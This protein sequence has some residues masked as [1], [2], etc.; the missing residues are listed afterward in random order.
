MMEQNKLIN[1]DKKCNV[2]DYLVWRGDLS[3]DVSPF[4]EVDNIV[5]SSLI[6]VDFDQIIPWEGS[7]SLTDAANL[8]F[9]KYTDEEILARVS[10]TKMSAFLMRDMIHTRRFANIRLSHYL[11]DISL[12]EESQFCAMLVDLGDG[13]TNVVYSGTDS[14][15]VGWKENFNMSFLDYTPGQKKAV[16][17]LNQIAGL[18][19]KKIRVMGHSKGGNL[20][21][22]AAV[23]CDPDVSDRIEI[24]YSNDGPGFSQEEV[25]QEAYMRMMPKI[26]AIVPD[27]CIVGMMLYHEEEYKIVKSIS[28][29]AKQHDMLSWEVQGDH[30]IPC[31]A[32]KGTSKLLDRT[33]KSWVY[34]MEPAQREEFVN[35]MF[36][37][38]EQ[39]EITTVD[40]LVGQ[41]SKKFLTFLKLSA[42]LD[43][44]SQE[45][46]KTSIQRLM[47]ESGNAIK[48]Y[49]HLKKL[50]SNH[51]D[52]IQ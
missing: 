45:A 15:I 43:K 47:T 44:T 34:H 49:V 6:Y 38:L 24:V 26:H 46:L 25:E 14:T 10:S 41:K 7:I 20:S 33:L 1:S 28:T 18:D 22:Y 8:F 37:I 52:N 36:S 23:H 2:G 35:A 51:E 17:Y 50:E 3:F 30:L 11:N 39:A 48:E 31:E 5:L 40:D 4:N 19:E 13:Y 12:E 29:G 27:S 32:I 9:E 16:A 21:V 42:K